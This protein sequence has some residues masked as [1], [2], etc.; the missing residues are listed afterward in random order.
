MWT[1][2]LPFLQAALQ[3][4]SEEFATVD[5]DVCEESDSVANTPVVV[6]SVVPVSTSNETTT[7]MDI[8]KEFKS[9]AG[10]PVLQF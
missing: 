10:L 8:C 5:A 7:N 4:D 2:L 6:P 1:H 3:S 9:D